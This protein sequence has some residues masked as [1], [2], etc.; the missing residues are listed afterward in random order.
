MNKG[1]V[2]RIFQILLIWSFFSCFTLSFTLYPTSISRFP[3]INTSKSCISYKSGE[4]KP[5]SHSS[6]LYISSFCSFSI[7]SSTSCAAICTQKSM[8][9]L[10]S[11]GASGNAT[12]FSGADST[13]SLVV[14]NGAVTSIAWGSVAIIRPNSDLNA[15]FASV[16]SQ[17]S[18]QGYLFQF[19]NM[20]A[21]HVSF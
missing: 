14:A 16:T 13:S 10:S 18:L 8:L 9:F 7:S 2:M 15:N 5:A 4:P 3:R 20:M 17:Q 1:V 12:T 21:F 11:F 19:L 6:I